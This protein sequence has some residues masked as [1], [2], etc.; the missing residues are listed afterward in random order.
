M[1][2]GCRGAASP[3]FENKVVVYVPGSGAGVQVRVARVA[4]SLVFLTS[5]DSSL[6]HTQSTAKGP[7]AFFLSRGAIFVAVNP[8]GWGGSSKYDVNEKRLMSDALLAADVAFAIRTLLRT[9]VELRGKT[10]ADVVVA[11]YSLGGFR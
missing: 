9:A 6:T 5:C 4:H 7:S 3:A 10:A 8:R 2:P 11:G 1:V